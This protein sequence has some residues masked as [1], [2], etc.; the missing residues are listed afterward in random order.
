MLQIDILT[1]NKELASICELYWEVDSNLDFVHKIGE[2]AELSKIDKAKLTSVI[3][4]AC[5]AY[6]NDWKCSN[7]G[8]PFIFSGRSE[9]TRNRTLLI[10]ASYLQRSFICGECEQKRREKETLE[11]KRQDEIARK[12]RE[13]VEIDLRSK[14]RKTYD[15]SNHPLIDV[16][17]LSLTDIIYLLS[18]LRGGAYESLTKIMPVGMFEQPLSADKDFSTEII[19]YLHKNK[20]IYVHPDTEPAA[21]VNDDISRFYIYSVYYAPPI[22][23]SAPDDPKKLITELLNQVDNEW[24]DERCQ[25][26]L[27]IWKKVALSECKEYLLFVLNEHHFEFSPG[28][29]TTQYLEY[30]LEHFSTAQIYNTIWRAAKDSAAYFQRET[31]SKRQAA[32]AAIAS[33][34]RISERA[35]AENWE[36][37][38]YGRNYKCPQTVISEV[39]YNSAI[40]LGDDG[41]RLIPNLE[42]IR[43][44]KLLSPN[45]K[46]G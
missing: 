8:K 32:N 6:L 43:A 24:S 4:E 5:N 33:I 39:L 25:E 46:T 12:A 21:F 22:S 1:E 13:A 30:A 19:T 29:K 45:S 37:K 14:I 20:L 41:F 23:R 17:N 44:K 16:E 34:Q 18:I 2:L 26:A 38:P 31:I 11:K 27:E 36:I 7:C 42:T 3:R 28:E 15:L 35:V 10:N 9:F 40:K